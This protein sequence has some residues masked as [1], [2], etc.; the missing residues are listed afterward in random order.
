MKAATKFYPN[1]SPDDVNVTVINRGDQ[2]LK[3]LD[4]K[5]GDWTYRHLTRRGL[6]VR[7][8]EE[9]TAIGPRSVTLKSDGSELPCST[10]VWAAGIQS[11]P[12]VKHFN[13]PVDRR[14][15]I[16]AER[17]TKVQGYDHVWAIGD[18]AYNPDAKGESYPTTAQ[19]AIGMGQQCAKNIQR[20][21]HREPTKPVELKNKGMLAAFGYGDAIGQI[22]GL[23]ITGWLAWFL[24]RGAYLSKIPGL[25]R[26]VR[27]AADWTLD[28]VTNRDFVELGMHKL[29][30]GD[31]PPAAK[32]D[33][34][35]K[36]K[37]PTY[38]AAG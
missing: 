27:V 7:L 29:V 33:D 13:L 36:E 26:K 32:P 9:T 28:L 6:D 8:N 15:Y 10:V 16:L 30:R 17:D 21:M 20:A 14:G 23:T 11:N 4:P 18:G 19:M 22:G 31:C 3:A 25:S 2:L 38:A 1:V 24:W 37:E 12:V 35:P 5:L 34:Q